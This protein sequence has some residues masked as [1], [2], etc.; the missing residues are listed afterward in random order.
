MAAIIS[1]T[2]LSSSGLSVTYRTAGDRAV[3]VEYGQQFPVDLALNFFV[4]ATARR[5][6]TNPVRGVL[7]VVPGLRS[8]LAHYDP[9]VIDQTSVVAA[10]DECHRDMPEPASLVLPS[11]R[12]KLPIAFDDSTSRE[13]VNRYRIS[14]RPDAPNVVDG[15]NIDYIVACNGLA[16]RESF[17][18]KVLETQW[19]NAF[20]GFYPGLPSL[21]PLDPR[22]EVSAPKYN[23]ARAW[24]PEGAVA[25]GGP[26][27]VIHPI[28]SAGAYQIFG[29]TLPISALVR[30]PRAHRIDPLL[31]YPCDRISFVRTSEA[32]L[33]ELRRQVF[34]GR[35]DYDIEPGEYAVSHH[36]ALSRDEQV[37]A[38]VDRHRE[39]RQAALDLVKI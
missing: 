7:E 5:L 1:T 10:L 22:S 26:C 20:T 21:L 27:L 38:G 32:E 29:R 28:E 9:L 16:D 6:S 31:I 11:R 12:V 37:A 39:A 4:H 18:A 35:Y 19:W 17:Y 14:T 3:L 36:F 8:L 23:P 15:N 24:T 25:L 30:N 33:V 2:E 34:E 13:A